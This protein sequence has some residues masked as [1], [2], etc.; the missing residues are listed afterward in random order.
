MASKNLKGAVLWCLGMPQTGKTGLQLWMWPLG[1]GTNPS[2]IQ[3]KLRKN[4]KKY[5]AE[6]S[7]YLR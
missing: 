7:N 2:K 6:S 5:I 4:T 3:E 1:H